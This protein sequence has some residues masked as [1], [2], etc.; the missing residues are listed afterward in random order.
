PARLPFKIEVFRVL[1]ESYLQ[2]NPRQRERFI[3][4]AER[5]YRQIIDER[6]EES[7][8]HRSAACEWFNVLI[9]LER[10]APGDPLL[11]SAIA[12]VHQSYPEFQPLD[13][14]ELEGQTEVGWIR[15]ESALA[16]EEIA[17]LSLLQWLEELEASKERGQQKFDFTDQVEGFL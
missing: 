15:P 16:S 1:R 8:R 10:T 5:L 11:E 9:W 4:R 13:H 12:T 6:E 14:P 3:K 17:S 2:L 7:N